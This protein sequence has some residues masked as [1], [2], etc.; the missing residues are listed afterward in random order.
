MEA[1]NEPVTGTVGIKLY[2]GS[3]RVVARDSPNAVY[4]A[5]LATFHESGGLFSQ[6]A[7]PGFVELFSLQ[8]RMAWRIRHRDGG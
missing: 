4:D 6:D 5:T 3:A 7:A 1:A 8:S 2:K